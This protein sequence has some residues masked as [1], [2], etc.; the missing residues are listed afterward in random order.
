MADA[1]RRATQQRCL[2]M[3]EE[4]HNGGD[5]EAY[6]LKPETPFKLCNGSFGGH[7]LTASFLLHM[8]QGLKI[9]TAPKKDV[10]LRD[11]YDLDTYN[12]K[13]RREKGYNRLR[14]VTVFYNEKENNVLQADIEDN[15][16]HFSP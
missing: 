13:Y 14:S 2:L 9:A 12:L 5:D 6:C 15:Y 11:K 4:E 1:K 8:Y 16:L 10:F 3:M 7:I